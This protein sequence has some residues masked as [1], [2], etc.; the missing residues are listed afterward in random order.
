MRALLIVLFGSVLTL[1]SAIAQSDVAASA[2]ATSAMEALDSATAEADSIAAS[3]DSAT[4]ENTVD[5]A[6]SSFPSDPSR[7]TAPED[8]FSVSGS[9]TEK[10]QSKHKHHQRKENPCKAM[11]ATAEQREKIKAAMM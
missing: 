5:S 2:G 8:D 3:V 11:N 6:H 4:S 10:H 9:E 1:T 7:V